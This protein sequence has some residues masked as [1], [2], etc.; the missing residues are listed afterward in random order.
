VAPERLLPGEGPD[1]DHIDDAR[2]W[3]TVYSELLE[4]KQRMLTIIHEQ[5][6]EL[7]T[8]A[9][10]EVERTDSIG[11]SAEAERFARRLGFWRRRLDEL[12]NQGQDN[13]TS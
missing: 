4:F 12:S 3:I 2:H 1:S 11:V 13:A 7:G 9:R 10:A 6:K 8:E 5:I